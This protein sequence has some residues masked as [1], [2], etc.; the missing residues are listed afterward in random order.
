MKKYIRKNIS[1]LGILALLSC[2]GFLDQKPQKSLLVPSTV[3]DVRALLDNY[4]F[5]M[6]TPLISWIMS[7]EWNTSDIDF[8][9]FPTWQ[10]HAFTWQREI[11]DPQERSSDYQTLHSQ[12]FIA[13]TA[14]G[15]IDKLGN[16]NSP[17]IAALKGEALVIRA[18]VLFDLAVLFLPVP[19]SRLTDQIKIPVNLTG[20]VNAPLM[21][22]GTSELISLAKEELEKAFLLLPDRSPFKTRPDKRV[23]KGFLARIYLYEQNWEK[24]LESANYVIQGGDKL[25]DLSK[26]N[27]SSSY[28]F[29]LFNEETVYYQQMQ[30]T[31]LTIRPSTE[32]GKDLYGSY[33]P[34]D[35]R[36]GLF[37]RLNPTQGALFKGS[38][39]GGF[40]LF[41]GISLSEMYLTA[42]EAAIRTG[43]VSEGLQRLNELGATRYSAFQP[44]VGLSQEKALELT[45]GE[46]RKELVFR[47]LRWMDMK[48]INAQNP[49]FTPSRTL[50][51]QVYML[52]NEEQYILNIPPYEIE[53]G[54]R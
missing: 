25:L 40:Q 34:N 14:L 18:R 53:L 48:R 43:K 12:M 42:A 35:R 16:Q 36:R 41:T 29:S 23:A 28:P 24:A 38:Y 50:K 3:E 22:I 8:E 19:Q 10:Q 6:L 52:E 54:N 17:E 15:L 30:P 45:M 44:W 7:D 27:S 51:G 11:F 32:I 21:A 47:G 5:L 4:N 20:D 26:L 1:A 31:A 13:H 33:L 37:F 9:T 39:S 49:S 46:R 2:E